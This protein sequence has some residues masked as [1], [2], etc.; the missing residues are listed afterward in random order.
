M[1]KRVLSLLLAFCSVLACHLSWQLNYSDDVVA[2][3]QAARRV[4]SGLSLTGR[5]RLSPGADPDPLGATS[6]WECRGAYRSEIWRGL[7]RAVR[8]L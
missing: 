4:A 1:N 3:H 6:Q 7:V 5:A 8:P 2:S